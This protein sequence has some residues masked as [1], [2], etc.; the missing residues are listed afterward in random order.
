[1]ILMVIFIPVPAALLDFLQIVNFSVALLIL[2]LTFCTDKPPQLLDVS[3]YYF[4]RNTVSSGTKY[5]SNKT[6]IG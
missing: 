6:D 1:M 5:F 4:D 2:L 3:F